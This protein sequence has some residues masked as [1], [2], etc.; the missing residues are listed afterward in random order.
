[1]THIQVYI[2]SSCPVC[3]YSRR[4]AAK[5]A[6]RCPQIDIELIDIA[7][8]E[9]DLPDTVFA[10]PTWLWDGRLFSLGNPDPAQVWRRLAEVQLPT[11]SIIVEDNSHGREDATSIDNGVVSGSV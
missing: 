2:A 7:E 6:E 3:V 1:M 4:L 11:H 10:T 9:H 5:I 8:A